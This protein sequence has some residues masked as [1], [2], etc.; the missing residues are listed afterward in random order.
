MKKRFIWVVA[1]VVFVLCAAPWAYSQEMT[2]KQFVDEA[3][4]LLG[5]PM[6][7]EARNAAQRQSK[8]ERQ[9]ELSA[10]QMGVYV[11]SSIPKP[12]WYTFKSK[13][14]LI[15]CTIDEAYRS[16]PI[17]RLQVYFEYRDDIEEIIKFFKQNGW[18]SSGSGGSPTSG[19]SQMVD[20]II[21]QYRLSQGKSDEIYEK[22]GVRVIRGVDQGFDTLIFSRF[23]PTP[24]GPA[25]GGGG[26]RIKRED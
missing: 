21:S 15:D 19:G 4:A 16:R 23:T 5:S 2:A 22:G 24:E 1:A 17:Q 26:I 9:K 7:A 18:A 11:P 10:A 3:I 12:G 25:P 8:A 13:I 20:N 14:G 6:P